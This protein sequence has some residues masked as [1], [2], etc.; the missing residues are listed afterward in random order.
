MAK[1]HQTY[2]VADLGTTFLRAAI[3]EGGTLGRVRRLPVSELRRDPVSGIVDAVI[4]EL[5]SVCVGLPPPAAA[6]IGV[7]TVVDAAGDLAR[8]LSAGVA[9]GSFL[10]DR[11]AAS[12]GIR[13]AVDNDVNMA[14][15]GEL[16]FGAG[17]DLGDFVFL[18]LG[19]YLGM[20]AVID[21]DVYRGATGGA[22]EIG[23]LLV[24]VVDAEDDDAGRR[25]SVRSDHFG[26]GRSAA[27][28]GYAWLEELV[29]GAA[30]SAA[31]GGHG[32]DGAARHVLRAAA[33]GDEASRAIAE[34]AVEGW[35]YAIATITAILDPAAVIIGGGISA[36]L[37]P[38]LESL[39]GR[40]RALSR[41]APEVL[42]SE[43]GDAAA[44]LGA[45][46]AARRLVS[47]VPV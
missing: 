39:R 26:Q 17:G 12:L 21:G 19:T 23:E 40:V 16:A 37:L 47:D 42:I 5:E 4:S 8:S 25:R 35:A 14:A 6:G 41:G 36:D 10:R 22:G 30:L 11:A 18:A 3:V 20:A 13:V 31:R 46:F 34:H 9:S 2:L 7:P 33:R 27:P 44:L 43:L 15:R 38:F 1:H 24:P 29:G 45:Q 32:P 28:D